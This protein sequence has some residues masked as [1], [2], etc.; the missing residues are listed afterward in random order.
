[1]VGDRC[2]RCHEDYLVEVTYSG[3]RVQI[4]NQMT[5][6]NAVSGISDLAASYLVGNVRG[7]L[8]VVPGQFIGD[9]YHVNGQLAIDSEIIGLH[10]DVIYVLTVPEAGMR[11]QV[12]ERAEPME[13]PAELINL[14]DVPTLPLIILRALF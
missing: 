5:G 9:I 4:L 2:L 6:E 1:M 14:N 10:G 8:S 3:R 11:H 12:A 7:M 13:A